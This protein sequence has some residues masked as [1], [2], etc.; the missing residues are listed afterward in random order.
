M[1]EHPADLSL[2][3]YNARHCSDCRKH[4]LDDFITFEEP[5]RRVRTLDYNER[6]EQE[7]TYTAAQGGEFR[8]KWVSILIVTKFKL[9]VH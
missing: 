3:D 5:R 9:R 7:H 8:R 2:T 1:L 4:D 6:L